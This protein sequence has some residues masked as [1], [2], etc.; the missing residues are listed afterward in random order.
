MSGNFKT[1]GVVHL[2]P[3]PGTPKGSDFHSVLNRAVFDAKQLFESG[4]GSCIVENFG[5]APFRA[6]N[7]DAHVVAFMTKIIT[8]IQCNTDLE[9]GINVLRNDAT[10]ALAIASACDGDFI[11]VN[12]HTG[13]SWTDQGLIE[14]NAYHTLMYRNQILKNQSVAIAAD[15]FVK[16]ASPAG[17]PDIIQVAKDTIL[18]GQADHLILTGAET[19]SITDVDM[20][21]KIRMALPNASI[22]I[23]SGLNPNNVRTFIPFSN[24]GIVGSYFH[25][26]GNLTEPLDMSRIKY[27]LDAVH[28][29]N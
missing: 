26:D 8:E 16:H 11:R 14:G 24:A 13:S 4:V 27:F 17:N 25:R 3:L 2:Q 22:W 20:V 9:I 12:V 10:A 1:I 29:L 28:N 15:I 21:Q 6:Q 23:G 19:G 5:D 7:V 18:R